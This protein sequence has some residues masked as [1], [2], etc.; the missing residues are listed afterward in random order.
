MKEDQGFSARETETEVITLQ[1]EHLCNWKA[2]AKWN[3]QKKKKSERAG[4]VQKV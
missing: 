2:E 1:S 4:A 3:D